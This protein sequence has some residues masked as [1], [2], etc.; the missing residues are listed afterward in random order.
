MLRIPMRPSPRIFAEGHVPGAAGETQRGLFLSRDPEMPRPRVAA[1]FTLIELLVVIAIVGILA[2]LMLPALA[3]S[4]SK[5]KQVACLAAANQLALSVTLY[6]S[7][8]EETF[9][10]STDYSAP[11]DIPERLWTMRLMPY[12][13][14]PRVLLCPAAPKA[15][16]ASNW[17]SRGVGSIGYS[18]ATA[19]DPLA[20][21]GFPTPTTVASM[22]A[23]SRTPLFG[24][25][26]SGPTE[27]KYRGYVFDPYNGT[28]H[29]DDARLGTPLVA[30]HD[31]VIELASLPP[32]ALK[33][34]FAR[35]RDRVTLLFGDGHAES[36][37]PRTILAQDRGAHFLWRFRPWPAEP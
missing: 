17:T 1:G 18:T 32:S 33:P 2:S 31:L 6:A 36:C 13:Q 3:Q 20:K 16:F 12:L 30:N 4:K 35:H 10:P 8:H 22:E 34:L 26:A 5:A 23:P 27:A 37:T 25:T 15:G 29:P 11:T 14:N 21:E 7:D 19:Y 28:A 24:D 9:P